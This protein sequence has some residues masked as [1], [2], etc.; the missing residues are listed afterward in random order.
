MRYDRFFHNL[1]LGIV[2]RSPSLFIWQRLD[3]LLEPFFRPVSNDS[4][5]P[6][7]LALLPL[8]QCFSSHLQHSSELAVILEL[9]FLRFPFPFCPTAFIFA[10]ICQET[11]YLCLRRF[12]PQRSEALEFLVILLPGPFQVRERFD[13]GYVLCKPFVSFRDGLAAFYQCA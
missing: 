4:P 9:V 6:N 7:L 3:Y 5:A 10:V 8:A 11:V 13:L 1:Q 2:F 12:P